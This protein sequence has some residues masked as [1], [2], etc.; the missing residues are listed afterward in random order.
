MRIPTAV[1]GRTTAITDPFHATFRTT[2]EQTG[3]KVNWGKNLAVVSTFNVQT[4]LYEQ[5]PRPSPLPHH[6]IKILPTYVYGCTLHM[7][8]STLY[9]FLLRGIFYL[10]CSFLNTVQLW[11]FTH[12]KILPKSHHEQVFKCFIYVNQSDENTFQGI[13]YRTSLEYYILNLRNTH[14][15]ATTLTTCPSPVITTCRLALTFK[16]PPACWQIRWDESIACRG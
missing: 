12:Y 3:Q 5:L 6:K 4:E 11:T 10:H 8:L 2:Y 16:R 15:K 7:R 9:G 14:T 13:N 1:P